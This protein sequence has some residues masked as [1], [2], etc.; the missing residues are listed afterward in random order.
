[1]T[2]THGIAAVLTLGLLSLCCEG[3]A[4]GPEPSGKQV[5]APPVSVQDLAKSATVQ[6]LGSRA[7]ITASAPMF[8]AFALSNAAT[9]Y[10]LVRGPSLR[11][12][13]VTQNALDAPWTR[14]Y[15][16][17]GVDLVT[18]AGTLGFTTCLGSA[19][20]DAPVVTY[21]Q[22]VRN[23]PV[24][25]RDSCVAATLPA[26]VYT[27]SVQPSIA[28]VT[29]P[30]GMSS[31]PASGEILFEVT[32][33]P[34]APSNPNLE[35]S[36]MLLGGTWTYTYA[37]ISTF[38]DSY[39]FT[40]ISSTPDSDG[41]YLATGTSPSGRPVGGLYASKQAFWAVLYQSILIDYFYTFNFSDNN[42][43]SGCYYQVNPSGS[44]NLSRCYPMSGIRSPFKSVQPMSDPE[45]V[46]LEVQQDNSN[47]FIEPG[48][49]E[50]YLS[51]KRAAAA[52]SR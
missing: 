17:T 8:G 35:K 1:M 19:A 7:T 46:L 27:F 24:G 28:G 34:T 41:D 26:G 22:T 32:L 12:L 10:L 5:I 42:H 20:T 18:T 29:S 47:A 13:G 25:A 9:V 39:N 6:S 3:Q 30:A 49:V 33:G 14:L 31:T 37:I 38:S 51:L 2:I 21:Y 11:T 44:T 16:A 15:N 48:A 40:S 45:K 50:A 23:A 36:A 4:N 52:G 43:V